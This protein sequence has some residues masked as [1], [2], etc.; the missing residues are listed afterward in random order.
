[1]AQVG[2]SAVWCGDLSSHIVIY[3]ISLTVYGVNRGQRV[4]F[5]QPHGTPSCMLVVNG[6]VW[7]GTAKGAVAVYDAA[8]TLRACVPDA[9][10]QVPT[11]R[12]RE[13][14][15]DSGR[16][17]VYQLARVLDTVLSASKSP[18]INI[19]TLDGELVR[20]IDTQHEFSILAPITLRRRAGTSASASGT[21]RRL[22]AR[23]TS[24][25]RTRT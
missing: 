1:L 19:W 3:P 2:D 20:V 4:R 22:S 13:L 23:L 14:R 17:Q 25:T 11:L 7:I 15:G 6:A 8:A 10:G 5:P 12:G 21:A 18:L 9:S 16:Q 24:R